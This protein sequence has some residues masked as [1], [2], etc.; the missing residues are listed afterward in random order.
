MLIEDIVRY[1]N[2]GKDLSICVYR[3]KLQELDIII[4]SIYII[5]KGN[6]GYALQV[7]FDPVGMIDFGEGWV[8]E[9]SSISIGTAI[10][11]VER[12]SGK[13]L[14]EWEN[15][16]KTGKLEELVL[17]LGRDEIR[18]QNK[19][20]I[21]NYKGGKMHLPSLPQSACWEVTPYPPE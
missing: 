12:F 11:V 8:W 20:F 1:I 15:I 18:R 13:S 9:T 14:S 17:E 10:S 2:M 7:V 6:N 21:H 3:E 4:L 5:S 16:S 19:E